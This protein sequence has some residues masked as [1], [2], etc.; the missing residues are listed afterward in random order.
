MLDIGQ[1]VG[2]FYIEIPEILELGSLRSARH[3][4]GR[5]ISL[6]PLDFGLIKFRIDM[7]CTC[8]IFMDG[9]FP[10][11]Y[12]YFPFLLIVTFVG[13]DQPQLRTN[14]AVINSFGRKNRTPDC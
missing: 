2:K 7:D 9:P 12:F 4:V 1:R 11:L 3:K 6:I 13:A 5:C 10:I 8:Y 14:L